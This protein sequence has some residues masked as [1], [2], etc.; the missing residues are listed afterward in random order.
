MIGAEHGDAGGQLIER[1][2]MGIDHAGERNAHG[3]RFGGVEPDAGAAGL[4]AEIE[5]IE[6]APRAG[7]HGRQPA[8]IGAVRGERAQNVVARGAV[9]E[10]EAPRDGVGCAL[11]FDRARIGGVGEGQLARRVARPHRRRQVL[12]Q[13]A[14]RRDFAQQALVP[15]QK[16]DQVALDAAGILQ[17]QHGAAADGAALHFDRMAVQRGQGQRKAFAA[18]AQVFDRLLHGESLAGFEP[19]A[20]GE[21]AMRRGNA[22]D[23]GIAVDVGLVGARRP[24]HHHL[25]LG[26]QQRIGAVEIAAQRRDL[27]ARGR[28]QPRPARARAHQHDRGDDGEQHEAE[29]HDQHGDFMPVDAVLGADH[30]LVQRESRLL[31]GAGGEGEYGARQ[32]RSRIRVATDAR[33]C[34]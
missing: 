16:L 11:G 15:R 5:H 27:V 21:H 23:A 30:E 31:L 24:I 26:K 1:A 33:S 28:L 18:A 19:A 10:L 7:D 4:G 2:A 13:G 34:R 29:H 25:R 22:D 9:E 12:D 14:Q 20:E 6:G 17:A 32:W 8:R 3:F